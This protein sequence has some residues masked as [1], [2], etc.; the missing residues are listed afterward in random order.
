MKRITILAIIAG[1]GLLFGPVGVFAEK[2]KPVK[3]MNV[4]PINVVAPIEA[5]VNVVDISETPKQVEVVNLPLPVEAKQALTPINEGAVLDQ[6]EIC[7]SI[8]TVPV[9]F[10]LIIEYVS[11][12][13]H[14]TPAYPLMP[15]IHISLNIEKDTYR[16]Q[17]FLNVP[18]HHGATVLDAAF[19]SGGHMTKI[20][21]PSGH[22][23]ESCLLPVPGDVQHFWTAVIN[24]SGQLIPE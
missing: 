18:A 24:F 5:P 6:D 19:R 14:S 15:I 3:V 21:V 2:P 22:L 13:M 11:I 16:R 17:A 7:D 12:R 8:Y 10:T 20:F 9:G 4:E 1:V 23:I